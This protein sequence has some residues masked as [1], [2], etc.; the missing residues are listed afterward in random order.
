M[1]LAAGKAIPGHWVLA[2]MFKMQPTNAPGVLHSYAETSE[3][4]AQASSEFPLFKGEDG[5]RKTAALLLAIAW[6]ESRFNPTAIG[7]HGQSVGLFQIQIAT[8][9]ELHSDVTGNMLLSPRDAAPIALAVIRESYRVCGRAGWDEKLGWYAAGGNGCK[10]AGKQKSIHRMH[11]AERIRK[12]YPEHF[13][14]DVKLPFML[15]GASE[16]AVAD[17]DASKKEEQEENSE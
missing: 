5:P 3:A 4:I 14:D 2:V 13:E 9:K 17:A 6:Y 8:A 12:N 15:L 11:M 1:A 10:D 16:P 7:D